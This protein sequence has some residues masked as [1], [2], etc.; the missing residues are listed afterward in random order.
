MKKSV[1]LFVI[2]CALGYGVAYLYGFPRIGNTTALK[3]VV[4]IPEGTEFQ[5]TSSN[6]ESQ[7]EDVV[8][9][10]HSAPERESQRNQLSGKIIA[11]QEEIVDQLK[12]LIQE[13]DEVQEV[14][15]NRD[16]RTLK[17]IPSMER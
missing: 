3:K 5:G 12:G 7:P 6:S 10:S 17:L 11:S 16:G 2:G 4:Q 15:V 1:S 14:I 13:G 9:Q 8:K